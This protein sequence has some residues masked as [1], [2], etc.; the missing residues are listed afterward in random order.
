MK[1]RVLSFMFFLFA[2]L[3]LASLSDLSAQRQYI[4]EPGD[5]SVGILN[6][7]IS[8]DTT[9]TGARVDTNTVYILRRGDQG[10]YLLNGSIREDFPVSIAAEEGTGARPKIIPGVAELGGESDRPFR[11]ENDLTLKSLYVT[12]LDALGSLTTRMIRVSAD[13]AVITIDD[14]YIE[15]D[16]QSFV[17][18]DVD[19]CTVSITNSTIANIG[20]TKDPSN[21][22][23]IDDRGNHVVSITFEN[24]TIYNITRGMTRDDGGILGSIVFRNNTVFNTGTT[25]FQLGQVIDCQIEN[26]IFY[27]YSYYADTYDSLDGNYGDCV[28]ADS[29]SQFWLDQG[30]TQNIRIRNNSWHIEDAY[31]NMAVLGDSLGFDDLFDATVAAFVGQNG[32]SATNLMDAVIDFTNPPV[33]QTDMVTKFWTLG[34]AHVDIPDFDV[35]GEPYDF[36]YPADAPQATA[37]IDGKPLGDPKWMQPATGTKNVFSNNN[38]VLYPNPANDYIT[39][40]SDTP[41][42]SVRIYDI[43]GKSVLSLNKAHN[44]EMISISSLNKGIYLVNVRFEDGTNSAIKMMK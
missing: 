17:R 19:S 34:Q 12:G 26:N 27:N 20:N 14:C 22:R 23:I 16:G 35:T 8:G 13:H 37:G 33:A 36:S 7:A 44:L 3:L 15:R 25:L 6:D 32:D 31:R 38:I 9:E 10:V 42:Q 4:V 1:R 39:L 5:H 21:G 41:I 30:Y 43:T 18:L 24:N 29:L 11:P 28:H 40:E 2:T